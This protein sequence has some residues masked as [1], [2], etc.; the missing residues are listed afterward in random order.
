LQRN[1]TQRRRPLSS[2]HDASRKGI[3]PGKRIHKV[4]IEDC[5]RDPTRVPAMLRLAHIPT[6]VPIAMFAIVLAA[7]LF[8]ILFLPALD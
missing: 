1:I 6:S 2:C 8:V 7:P 3:N 5:S 4:L